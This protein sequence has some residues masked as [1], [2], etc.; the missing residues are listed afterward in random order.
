MDIWINL[1]KPEEVR[2]CPQAITMNSLTLYSVNTFGSKRH[3][4][5][6]VLF[7]GCSSVSGV[8][9]S[10][11]SSSSGSGITDTSVCIIWLLRLM[12][13]KQTAREDNVDWP[14]HTVSRVKLLCYAYQ[15]FWWSVLSRIFLSKYY[16]FPI[17]FVSPW[18][19]GNNNFFSFFF[20]IIGILIWS[21]I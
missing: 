2:K 3:T 10:E 11:R 1:K 7:S 15:F 19:K 4:S 18:K 20:F 9:N 16:M 8:S 13:A 12:T 17:L 14:I 5:T 21:V 6:E